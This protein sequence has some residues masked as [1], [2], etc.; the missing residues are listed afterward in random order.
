MLRSLALAAAFLLAAAL[1]SGVAA[2]ETVAYVGATLWDGTGAP[3]VEG[4]TLVVR[5]G[6]VVA[7]GKVTT[8][9]G[10]RVENLAGRFV[11]PGLVD[12]HAHITGRWSPESVTDPSERVKADLGIYARY[13]ITSVMS[14]GGEPDAAFALRSE[15]SSPTLAR[16]RFYLAGPVITSGTANEARAA[17]RAN[18]ERNVDWIKIRVDDNLGSGQKMPTEAAIA[19]IQEAHARGLKIAA[20]IFYLADAK[21]LLENG[22][23]VV[24]HSV[25]DADVDEAVTL[26]LKRQGVC[27]IPTLVREISAFVYSTR[28]SFFDDPFFQAPSFAPEVARVSAPQEQQRMRESTAAMRY[29]EALV[30]A[31]KN[32]GKLME[33]EVQVAFGTD[34]GQPA[35]F[36][37]YFE[38]ME[39][40]LMVEAGLTPEQALR[41]ATSVAATCMGLEEVGTLEAGKWADFLVLRENPLD[42]IHG[43]RALERVY[44]AGNLVR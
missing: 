27:Y 1:P 12:A 20:H 21:V 18:A 19:A 35:R 25:R 29:R 31:Q 44:I 4:A 22:L 6:R 42:G 7:A 37:G 11:I 9:A 40:A 28:P 15:N 43:T 14:L 30:K 10:A 32:L 17:V 13:G 34:A 33:G 24:A 36:P 41:S 26:Q 8:P 16:S 5:G 2:Q 39:L 38:H 3:P 23:D